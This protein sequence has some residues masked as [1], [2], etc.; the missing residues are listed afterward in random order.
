MSDDDYFPYFEEI[1]LNLDNITEELILNVREKC[2]NKKEMYLVINLLFS[3]EITCGNPRISIIRECIN[4]NLIDINKKILG[5]NGF[6]HIPLFQ[7]IVNTDGE[8]EKNNCHVIELLLKNGADPNIITKKK[9]TNSTLNIA[10]FK[11]LFKIGELLIING[12]IV[13]EKFTCNCKFTCA[14]SYLLDEDQE[15]IIDFI[16]KFNFVNIKPAKK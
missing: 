5:N 14:F 1:K 11:R 4:Y 6:K 16:K 3:K 9:G 7:L 12:A 10:I 13:D 2:K 15:E 8:S